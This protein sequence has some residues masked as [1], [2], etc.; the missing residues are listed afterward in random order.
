MAV[1]REVKV[2]YEHISVAKK[3]LIFEYFSAKL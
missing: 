3:L 1:N 2:R